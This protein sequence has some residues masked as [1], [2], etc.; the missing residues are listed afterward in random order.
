MTMDRARITVP[1]IVM[2][3]GVVAILGILYPVLSDAISAQSSTMS[4]PTAFMFQIMLP[5]A[6]LVILARIFQKATVGGGQR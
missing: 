2:T 5:M 1:D 4:T 6:L 3:V